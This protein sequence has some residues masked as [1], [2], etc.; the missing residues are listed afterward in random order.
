MKEQKKDKKEKQSFY[1][2]GTEYKT[3]LPDGFEER[4][5]YER[6]QE[7]VVNAFIPGTVAK[8]Y[9][10]KGQKVRKG[11]KLLILEAMKMRNQ[12]LAPLDGLVGEVL[13]KEGERVTKGQPVVFLEREGEKE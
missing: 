3:Y 1:V 5:A 2:D 13:V 10:K 7:N 11:D 9:I 6:P 12:L 8:V 4:I